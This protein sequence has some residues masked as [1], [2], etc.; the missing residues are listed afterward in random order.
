MACVDRST[1]SSNHDSSDDDSFIDL[2][3]HIEQQGRR[4]ERR[5]S[6]HLVSG[7]NDETPSLKSPTSN[8]RLSTSSPKLQSKGLLG[9]FLETNRKTTRSKPGSRSVSSAP[10]VVRKMSSDASVGSRQTVS[11]S[12][13]QIQR[14]GV[15]PEDSS[16]PLTS[17][18][19]RASF[20][21]AQSSRFG[22]SNTSPSYPS[23]S[24]SGRNTAPRRTQSARTL[25]QP[26]SRDRKSAYGKSVGSSSLSRNRTKPDVTKSPGGSETVM[27]AKLREIRS[28]QE[29]LRKKSEDIKR[30]V[31]RQRRARRN[32][33]G[34]LQQPHRL[35]D[36][37]V[38][39]SATLN[40]DARKRL[41]EIPKDTFPHRVASN[42][43][44][45]LNTLF[46]AG[47]Q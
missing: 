15:R 21:R 17:T 20:S 37:I 18:R 4:A 16:N 30:Q 43:K 12:M 39:S 24:T 3:A 11:G 45:Y 8:R 1:S 14:M 47:T 34:T 40:S 7:D 5:N 44:V 25:L 26:T 9:S 27:K 36:T 41:A 6:Q 19:Q 23:S 38:G 33:T 29:A 28:E 46:T 10:A 31:S 32:S 42:S 13:R 35:S 2:Y 22:R